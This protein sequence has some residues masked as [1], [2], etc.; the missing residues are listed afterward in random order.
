M[1][2]NKGGEL[3]ALV[4]REDWVP[5]CPVIAFTCR[6][7]FFCLSLLYMERN[8]LLIHPQQQVYATCRRVLAQENF[9]VVAADDSLDT[10]SMIRRHNPCLVLTGIRMEGRDGYGVLQDIIAQAPGLPVIA[11]AI[12]ASIAGAVQF[13]NGGGADY[14]PNPFSADQL[15][16]AVLQALSRV[17][18]QTGDEQKQPSERAVGNETVE[19]IIGSSLA[20][21]QLHEKIARVAATDV[22]VLITGE[23]GTGKELTAREIHALSGRAAKPFMIVDCAALPP[24]LIESEMFGH[25]RGAFTGAE[26]ARKGLM[27]SGDHGTIFLDEIGELELASQGRLLRLLEDGSIRRVGES[28]RNKIDLRF[29]AATNRNLEDDAA[30]GRFRK[31]LYYRMKV[32][33]IFLPPLRER[34]EDIPALATHFFNHFRKLYERNDLPGL[35]PDLLSIL[36]AYEWPGNIRELKNLLERIVVLAQGPQAIVEEIK[37]YPVAKNNFSL[38]DQTDFSSFVADMVGSNEAMVKYSKTRDGLVD[39]LDRVYFNK[40]FKRHS[41]N[42]SAMARQA[43][44][45]RK[46]VYRKLSLLK[47]DVDKP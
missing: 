5:W 36:S 15:I 27:Q 14:L 13:I 33:E 26:R 42:I 20:I 2:I 21:Q 12:H 47:I 23:T 16:K 22:H 7:W 46:S 9:R 39:S 31:D 1:V 35:E 32:V 30:H 44:M 45:T 10:V 11:I 34:K 43:G 38:P 37:N 19:V 25:T 40:L 6:D 28:V 8:I 17:E 4:Y 3:G 18:N 29:V 24:G 41:G